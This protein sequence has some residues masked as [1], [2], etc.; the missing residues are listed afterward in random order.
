M[1]RPCLLSATK[2]VEFVDKRGFSV[3]AVDQVYNHTIGWRKA[4]PDARFPHPPH[5]SRKFANLLVLEF[6]AELSKGPA[7]S[8]RD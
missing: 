1:Q 7:V 8:L 5:E 6:A 3:A 2:M 4:C